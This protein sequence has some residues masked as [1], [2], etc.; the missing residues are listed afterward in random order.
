MSVQA[1]GQPVGVD[2]DGFAYGSEAIDVLLS[3]GNI[4]HFMSLD[5]FEESRREQQ[6][7]SVEHVEE[8]ADPP[9]KRERSEIPSVGVEARAGRRAAA[10][11]RP[12]ASLRLPPPQR[13]LLSL[14]V[15][16]DRIGEL[17]QPPTLLYL[18][19]EA[20]TEEAA[21][22]LVNYWKRMPHCKVLVLCVKE[23]PLPTKHSDGPAG[24]Q[25]QV[26]PPTHFLFYCK[27]DAQ[28]LADGRLSSRRP[29][30]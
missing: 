13:Q 8:A 28:R 24:S 6:E 12:T 21:T 3:Q 20:M 5:E 29:T 2:L 7:E 27:E 16:L 26:H 15:M 18:D 1:E 9:I 25:R 22:W 11:S 30:R 10:Q 23:V 14:S 17:K 19:V 4:S